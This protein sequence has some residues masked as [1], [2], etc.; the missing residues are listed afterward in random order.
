VVNEVK[1]ED[2]ILNC[3]RLADRYHQNPDV[4]VEMPL[5]KVN[6]HVYYTIRLNELQNPPPDENG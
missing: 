4:F 3:Y 2:V 1:P 5:S 6:E